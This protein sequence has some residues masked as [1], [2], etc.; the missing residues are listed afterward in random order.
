LRIVNHIVG[1]AFDDVD[2]TN[3]ITVAL[4]EFLL[5]LVEFSFCVKVNESSIIQGQGGKYSKSGG[6]KILLAVKRDFNKAVYKAQEV[7]F[8]SLKFEDYSSYPV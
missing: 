3:P 2:Q 6:H 1:L 4:I 5:S 8:E 7:P